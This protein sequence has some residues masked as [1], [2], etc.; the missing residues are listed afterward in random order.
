[1][2]GR[3]AGSRVLEVWLLHQSLPRY[4]AR[5]KHL[6]ENSAFRLCGRDLIGD[7]QRRGLAVIR[8]DKRKAFVNTGR[9]L[10]V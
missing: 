10:G 7:D 4:A 6:S 9:L 5:R 8:P 2:Q 1:M 3:R